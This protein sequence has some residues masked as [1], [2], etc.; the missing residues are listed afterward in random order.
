MR[1]NRTQKHDS[2][3]LRHTFIECLSNIA[4]VNGRPTQIPQSDPRFVD[5]YGRPCAKNW[6]KHFEEDM[7]R[8]DAALPPELLDIFK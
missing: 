5:Y 7:K 1:W 8:P 6:E 3:N 2:L 4:N